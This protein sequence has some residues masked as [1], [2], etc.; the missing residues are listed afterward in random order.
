VSGYKGAPNI[1]GSSK[2]DTITDNKGTNSITGGA[3]AD[4]FHFVTTN[5]GKTLATMDKLTDFT[6]ASGDL[7]F[8]GF[9]PI[10]VAQYGEGDYATFS[11]FASA[12]DSGN[13][14]VWVGNI[15]GTGLV[16]AVDWNADNTVDYM[17]QLVG[18]NNLNQID[19]NAFG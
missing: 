18:L 13:K 10:T 16:A 7:I 11:A 15:T 1:K 2:A 4:A 12:A 8:T 3:G 6:E 14:V 9:G 5:T 19:V 17:I